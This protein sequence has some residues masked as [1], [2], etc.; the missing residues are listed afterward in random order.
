MKFENQVVSLEL[1]KKLKDLGVKQ[2]SL[3]YWGESFTN[4]GDKE[5]NIYFN[6]VQACNILD[7]YSAFTV[8]ELGEMLPEHVNYYF[9]QYKENYKWV[10]TFSEHAEIYRKYRME[11]KGQN[12]ADVRA[13]M[14]IYLI[15]NKLMEVPK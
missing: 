8:A 2:D 4:N 14:L 1:A 7:E 5:F 10:I 15:E 9:L 13:Q 6:S 3:F 11:F 12:E